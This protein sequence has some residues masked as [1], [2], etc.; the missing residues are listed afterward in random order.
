MISF[1]KNSTLAA[2]NLKKVKLSKAI[3]VSAIDIISADL[4]ICS[5]KGMS[6]IL[7]KLNTVHSEKS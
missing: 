7:S 1:E 6:T 4:V 5:L 2:R 3:E